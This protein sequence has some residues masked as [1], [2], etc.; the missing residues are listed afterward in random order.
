MSGVKPMSSFILCFIAGSHSPV[1]T[2]VRWLLRAGGLVL[3]LVIYTIWR[4]LDRQF[5]NGLP[6]AFLRG[7]VVFGFLTWMWFV[8]KPAKDAVK[9]VSASTPEKGLDLASPTPAK[10]PSNDTPE[11]Q[12]WAQALAELESGGRK[13][14]LWARSFAEA[15]GNESLAQANYLSL[16]ARQL[17]DEHH[18]QIVKAQQAREQAKKDAA[19]ARLAE[20]Q[21]QYD[22]LPKGRCPSCDAVILMAAQECPKCRA[23]FATGS[24]WK[25]L[26]I[27]DA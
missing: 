11:D 12:Y 22:S 6:S 23:L 25:V 5:G 13:S 19:N 15:Q 27:K 21:R 9:T 20:E 8:T 10:N 26:P 24:A 14:G 7:A 2:P 1:S 17:A 3:A 18:E 16:R 4:Q